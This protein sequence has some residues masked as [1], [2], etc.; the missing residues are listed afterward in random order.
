MK[1]AKKVWLIVAA[2]LVLGGCILLFGVTSALGGGFAAL[3]GI[4][5][6][7]RTHEVG[8]G[9]DSISI[10]T[11]IA[12]IVFALSE[13]GKCRVECYEDERARHTVSVENDTL[14]IGVDPRPWYY[15]IGF[16]PGSPKVTVS[17]PKSQYASLHI[18]ERTGDIQIPDAFAFREVAISLSTG[19]V[20]FS[21]SASGRARI[22]T[23]TGAIRAEGFSAGSLDLRVTSGPVTVA[24]V[25]CEGDVTLNVRT[26]R[27]QLS[28][29]RCKS[30][31]SSGTTGDITLENV[32]AREKLSIQRTT[33]SVHFTGSDAAEIFVE[34]HTGEVTAADVDCEG[35]FTL[36]V[37]TGRA[38][39]SD[40]RCKSLDSSGTTGD[41]TL[42]NVTALEKF[43]IQRTTGSVCF[44]GS[45]AAEI[46]VET[47]TG[48]VTGSLLT[49]KVFIV[50]TNT[51]R[52]DV[53]QTLNGGS[54]EISTHT[55]DI[56]I[57]IG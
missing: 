37:R 4:G 57:T 25:D 43:S 11:D 34:T 9:F 55:G 5:Y 30:L 3:S 8:E 44:T 17:L 32:T 10:D 33:G 15:H 24:D 28:D 45:D 35:G 31:D 52:I 48:D 42:E 16:H 18:D 54:C 46:S 39:L 14:M 2:F 20:D 38:H 40:V 6:E 7:T 13:D 21:A 51:G 22:E 41:I 1:A 47:H 50:Q 29:V 19:G 53:P 56:R 26:G 27:A 36:N 23:T 12:D 49:D